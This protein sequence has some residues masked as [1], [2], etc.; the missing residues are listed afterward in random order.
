MLS[1]KQDKQWERDYLKNGTN[2]GPVTIEMIEFCRKMY[3]GE[4]YEYWP[5]GLSIAREKLGV[6]NRFKS[7]E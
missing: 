1:K 3:K 7:E 4:G 6:F 5:D 2:N